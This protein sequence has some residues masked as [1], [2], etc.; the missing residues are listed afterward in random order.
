MSLDTI[1]GSDWLQEFATATGVDVAHW[2]VRP[3]GD[4]VRFEEL[5][6][7]ESADRLAAFL[8][9]RYAVTAHVYTP[10]EH[11]YEVAVLPIA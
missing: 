7:E 10:L 6:D 5:P 11:G 4:N 1:A 3:W 8:R 9:Q 2:V